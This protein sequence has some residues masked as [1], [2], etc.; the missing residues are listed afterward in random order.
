MGHTNDR[1]LTTKSTGCTL[2]WTYDGIYRLTNETVGS[3]PA[4]KNGSVS[5]SLD[6]VGNRKSETST[7]SGLNPG[8]FNYNADDEVSTDIYDANGNTLATGGKAFTY[9]SENHLM[10]MN[11]GA[12]T[13][14]YDGDGNRVAKTVGGVTTRYLVD[15]FNPTGYSQVVEEIVNGAVEREY[16]YGIQLISQNQIVSNAWTPSFYQSD[17]EGSKRQLTN[18]AGAVTDTYEYDAFG[19]EINSTG[20]TPNN[21]LYRGEQYDS[22]LGMYYLRARYY[23]PLTGRFLSVDPLAG[24]GQRRYEYAGADPVNGMDPTGN[25]AIVEFA[26]LQFY[27]GRIPVHF[28]GFPTWCGLAMNGYLPGCGGTGG[29]GT[30]GGSGGGPGGPPPPPPP[31]TGPNC[32]KQCFARL[33][34]RGVLVK[35]LF[36]IPEYV[37]NHSFWLVQGSDG[38]HRVIDGGPANDNGT[39]SLV[40]W[41]TIGDVSRKYPTDNASAWTWWDSGTSGSVCDQVDTLIRVADTWPPYHLPP[42]NGPFGPNSNSFAHAVGVA[43]SFNPSKPPDAVAWG[44]P[45]PY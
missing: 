19:N 30:G 8:T 15:E 11:G 16:T 23:N 36:G 26:L 5:Y 21:Y 43:A 34:Y 40:D 17:G 18:A 14:L 12:V 35:G 4:N 28:P 27:P 22:D 25:E 7:L 20:T 33:K 9:D 2:N 45:I 39:G 13:L 29:N 32:C 42:Y 24:Q 31:C 3:D 38:L 1:T 41:D 37:G 44:Y 6:P 10:S